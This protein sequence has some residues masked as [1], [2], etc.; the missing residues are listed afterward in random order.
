MFLE[1]WSPL[2]LGL[3]Q[4]HNRSIL[5]FAGIRS[6]ATTLYGGIG[7]KPHADRLIAR[8]YELNRDVA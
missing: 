7:T 3:L 4:W 2:S 5:N 1:L 6:V 8:V